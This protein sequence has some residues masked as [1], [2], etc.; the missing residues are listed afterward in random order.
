MKGKN[1]FPSLACCLFGALLAFSCQD[2]TDENP[3]P[4]VSGN[5]LEVLADASSL[6]YENGMISF[7][8]SVTSKDGYTIREKG[9]C[10]GASAFPGI[11]SD[12]LIAFGAGFGSI[13]ASFKPANFENEWFV[14]SFAI[15]LSSSGKTDTT[16]SNQL[17]IKPFHQLKSLRLKASGTDSIRI[18]W[19]G[20]SPCRISGLEAVQSKGI[21]WSLSP[22]AKPENGN[23]ILGSGSDSLGMEVLATGLLP[24]RLYY[25]RSFASTAADTVF[26]PALGC[27]S[28]LTD[29][30]GNFYPSILIGKQVWMAANLRSSR[31]S[32]G[33]AIEENPDNARWDSTTAPANGASANNQVFGKLYN[34][35]CISSEK[36]LCPSGW[37]V[38]G[39]SDWDTLFSALGGWETAGLALKAG[40][41]AWGSS[42]PEGQGSSGF[43]ALPAG[44]KQSNGTLSFGGK[45]GFWW[46]AGSSNS[47]QSFRM[48]D[49]DKGVF[50]QEAAQQEGFSV[51][52][53]K[54]P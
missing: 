52:C 29:I 27:S 8:A 31:F 5:V 39:R 48:T 45:L 20:L 47:A 33:S 21:C 1:L 7:R 42:I 35:Y 44:L 14:R 11:K 40:T 36:N 23:F 22:A 37:K 49:L 53:L 10:F 12:S 9:I 6:R 18:S 15:S 16:Y 26:S 28:G 46:I 51:R 54:K 3:K 13:N 43:N 17:R 32:D 19:D 38:P 2:N 41:T 25:F 4:Q 34:Y 30:D 24:G 50:L